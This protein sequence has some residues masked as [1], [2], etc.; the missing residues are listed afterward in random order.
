LQGTPA[1]AVEHPR[2]DTHAPDFSARLLSEEALRCSEGVVI[3]DIRTTINVDSYNFSPM[4]R[5]DLRT[6]IALVYGIATPGSLLSRIAGL[7]GSHRVSPHGNTGHLERIVQIRSK[8]C[9]TRRSSLLM[10]V[11]IVVPFYLCCSASVNHA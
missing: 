11:I 10:S 7:P 8:I 2:T 9:W 3:N 5:L 1:D 4:G 6:D